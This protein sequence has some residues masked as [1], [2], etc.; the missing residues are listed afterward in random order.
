MRGR[1]GYI[2]SGIYTC[3]IQYG[4]YYHH[5]PKS[6]INFSSSWCWPYRRLH[7]L[8]YGG[9][10]MRGRGREGLHTPPSLHIERWEEEWE[11]TLPA[12]KRERRCGYQL[13]IIGG[14]DWVLDIRVSRK[15]ELG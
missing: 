2:E 15:L 10:E 13:V 11:V 14:C 9:G 5:V 12:Y 6:F 4:Q 1:G 8:N 7:S 3:E